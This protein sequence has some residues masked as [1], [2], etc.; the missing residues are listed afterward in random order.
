MNGFVWAQ[1]ASAADL[2]VVGVSL[3]GLIGSLGA[4]GAAV[5]VTYYF[6]CFLK[7]QAEKQGRMFQDFKDYHADSQKKLQEQVD[8]LTDRHMQSQ[9]TFQDQIGRITEVQNTLLREAVL[10][11]RSVEKTLESSTETI[12]S[13]EKMTAS[14]KTSVMA[15]DDLVRSVMAIDDLVRVANGPKLARRDEADVL[16]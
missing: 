8:R 16:A 2:G 5:I 4:A 13:V 15:I 9:R 11:M 14:L 3:T 1:A 10:A 6:L 12:C 7:D